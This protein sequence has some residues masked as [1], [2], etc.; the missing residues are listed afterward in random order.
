MAVR[1]LED[2]DTGPGHA[3]IDLG[4]PIVGGVRL[5]FRRL[6]AEPRDLGAEGWQS[7]VHWFETQAVSA[8]G[9]WVRVG[10]E[11]VN[12]IA[13]LVPVEIRSADDGVIGTIAWP[14]ILHSVAEVLPDGFRRPRF[15]APDRPEALPLTREAAPQPPAVAAPAARPLRNAPSSPIQPSPSRPSPPAPA[16]QEPEPPPAPAQAATVPS[17]LL[18][19]ATAVPATQ[20]LRNPEPAE[21]AAQPKADRPAPEP[22]PQPA[23]TRPRGDPP[24]EAAGTE[25]HRERSRISTDWL[26]AATAA[27]IP[28]LAILGFA[29][30]MLSKPPQSPPS[31]AASSDPAL[32]DAVRRCDEL[33]SSIF[34]P[35][36]PAT[37]PASMAP[38][39]LADRATEDVAIA[40]CVAAAGLTGDAIQQRRMEQQAGFATASRA[41]SLARAGD[42]VAAQSFMQAARQWW[43]KAAERGSAVASNDIG[44]LHDGWFNSKAN[45][46][47]FVPKDTRAAFVY[48]LASAEG[49]Y[50]VGL[51]NAGVRLIDDGGA[52]NLETG[53]NYLKQSADLGYIQPLLDLGAL[54]YFG[55]RDFQKRE[56]QGLNYYRRACARP[57]WMT[58]ARNHLEEKFRGNR[59]SARSVLPECYD[60]GP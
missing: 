20:L 11:V 3:V 48:F 56:D 39:P 1:V 54:Y 51:R 41:V 32:S 53:I 52:K 17:D 57:E 5:A 19:E 31:V 49:G 15:A 6:D 10:P 40:K 24:A 60:R 26:I 29:A 38:F 22:A 9:S 37:V 21:P 2:F 55:R 14:S 59:R 42:T 45:N 35:D 30:T 7:G 34:D 12:R 25:A 18:H 58:E 50:A 13:E 44:L 46:Y 4:R 47:S 33:A 27:V 16:R 23:T 8:G 43:T 36:R 28:F